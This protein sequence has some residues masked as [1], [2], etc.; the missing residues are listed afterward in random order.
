MVALHPLN[1]RKMCLRRPGSHFLSLMPPGYA[2]PEIPGSFGQLGTL[3]DKAS[4]TQEWRS[5]GR[6]PVV[7]LPARS[8]FRCIISGR[9]GCLPFGT[10]VSFCLAIKWQDIPVHIPASVSAGAGYVVNLVCRKE[11]QV[12]VWPS[13]CFQDGGLGALPFLPFEHREQRA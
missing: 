6:W 3:E 11:A 9:S 5:P 4:G 1:E 10:S 2:G 8:R 7:L 13:G 12:P